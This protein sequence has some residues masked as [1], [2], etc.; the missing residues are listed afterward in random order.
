MYLRPPRGTAVPLP[1]GAPR[2]F[3]SSDAAVYTSVIVLP[4]SVAIRS[5]ALQGR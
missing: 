3:A 4:N 2:K 1:A 5:A